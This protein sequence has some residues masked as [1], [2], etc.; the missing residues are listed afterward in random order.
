M[1]ASTSLLQTI[2]CFKT[3]VFVTETGF[4]FVG[5]DNK[6]PSLAETA[7]VPGPLI[8]CLQQ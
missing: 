4:I 1:P 5:P 3:V 6:N 8:I 2:V 7:V